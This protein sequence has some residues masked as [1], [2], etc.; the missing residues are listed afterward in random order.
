MELVFVTMFVD[1]HK[2]HN[3]ARYDI[4]GG[5]LHADLDKDITMILKGRHAKLMVQVTP[6]LYWTYISV[7]R[8]GTAILYVKMQKPT[9]GLLRSVLLLFYMKLVADLES[10]DSC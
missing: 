4:L 2:G 10:I 6:N 5:F 1:A 7:N 8:Q 3:T 9:N